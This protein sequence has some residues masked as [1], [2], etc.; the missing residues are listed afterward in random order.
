[1]H[2]DL[3]SSRSEEKHQDTDHVPTSGKLQETLNALYEAAGNQIDYLNTEIRG[4]RERESS[5]ESVTLD[6]LK[7][8]VNE[9]G[10]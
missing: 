4:L 7:T 10:K 8:G 9:R 2:A 3:P 1:M 6:S 5:N